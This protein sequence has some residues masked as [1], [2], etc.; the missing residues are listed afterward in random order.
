MR[1]DHAVAALALAALLIPGAAAAAAKPAAPAAK[2]AAGRTAASRPM[3]EDDLLRLEWIADPRISPDGTRIVFTRVTVDTAADNY[4]TSLWIIA[5]DGSAAAPRSLTG[6]AHDSQPRWSP[7]GRTLAFVRGSEGKPGQIYLLSMEG[8]EAFQLTRLAGGAGSPTWSPDGKT[9]AFTSGTNPALD[10]DSTRAKPKHDPGRVVTRPVFRLNG[11]GFIDPDHPDHL[12][13]IAVAGGT[14]RQLTTGRFDEGEPRWSHDGRWIYFVSDR[15]DEPWFSPDDQNL[16]AVAPDL[17]KPADGAAMKTVIDIDGPIGQ[18]TE[19]ADGRIAAIGW[20]ATS[21]P[22]SYDQDDLLLAEGPWPR[23]KPRNLTAE[24][25]FDIGGGIIS[26]Q[27]PPRGGGGGAPLAWTDDGRAIVTRVGRHGAS[28]LARIDAASG[29]VTELTDG[30]HEVVSANGTPDARRWA[31][32]MGDPTHPGVL[33]ALDAETRTVTRLW[34]PNQTFMA[35]ITL[36]GVEEF[37]YTSFDGT[38]IEAWIVKPPGFD[39]RKKYPAILEIHGGPHTA[40]GT[41]FFHEF[42]QLAGAGYVVLYTNPR[43]STTYGQAFGNIIQYR[44]PGDDVRDLMIGVD[45]LIARGYV[46]PKRLGVTGGSGGGLLT[47]WIIGHTDR[48]AAA[49]S[50]RPVADW[51]SF[52]YSADFTLFTPTWFRKPPY[53]DPNEYRERSPVTYAA[54]IHTPLMLVDGE[55]DWRTPF[56][57]SEAMFR[58]LAQQRKPVVM[59]RFPNESHELTRSGLP[60]HRVQNQHHLKAWFDKYLLGKPVTEYDL[61]RG[62]A[63]GPAH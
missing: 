13:T 36:G 31:L 39:A 42:Q 41:G 23:R 18:Y 16:Y 50:E 37:W 7:D 55:E 15:R 54:S 1:A 57:Q 14:P 61:P 9:I 21:P 4:R 44:Y 10:S 25:D 27:H 48:F 63:H 62:N 34:D 29:E 45:S 33:C 8:G 43:G 28:M 6:G 19:A 56:G 40:Y 5:G 30:Q 17:A 49:V 2:A 53:E 26:D 58:T 20:F 24:Y 59:I 46:D 52:Y 60:S 3:R 35:G 12:W 38:R 51:A 22:R 32:V 11:Q 47:N